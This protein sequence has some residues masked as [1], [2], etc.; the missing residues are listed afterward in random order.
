MLSLLFGQPD[1]A[2]AKTELIA[3][4]GIGS[5]AVQREVQRLREAGLVTEEAMH[6]KKWVQANAAS[7]L[8]GELCGIVDKT[9]GIAA[10]LRAALQPFAAQLRVALLFGSVAKGV[11][12]ADSDVDV[13][14]VSESLLLEDLYRVLAPLE[15]TLGRTI[16]PTLYT[17]AEF[18]ERQRRQNPF[19]VKVVGGH[20]TVLVGDLHDIERA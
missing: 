10:Q 9:S 20:H 13:L 2:F 17:G 12:R 19:V 18:L 7:P 11:D 4:A 5:G 1:R 14:V 8:F 3:L 15:A 16:S 6:G